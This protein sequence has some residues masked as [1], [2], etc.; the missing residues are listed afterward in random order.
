LYLLDKMMLKWRCEGDGFV[1]SNLVQN[2][3]DYPTAPY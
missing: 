3:P 2:P 1:L